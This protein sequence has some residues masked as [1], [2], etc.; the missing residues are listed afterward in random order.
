MG[1][2]RN[3]TTSGIRDRRRPREPRLPFRQ[4]SERRGSPSVFDDQGSFDASEVSKNLRRLNENL[5]ELPALYRARDVALD[6]LLLDSNRRISG[7]P[8]T[9]AIGFVGPEQIVKARALL[10]ERAPDRALAILLHHHVIPPRLSLTAPLLFCLDYEHVVDFARECGA[11]VIVHGH[12]HQPFILSGGELAVLSCGSARFKA[13]GRFAD[14]V[15][16]PSFYALRFE[17]NRM[18]AATLLKASECAPR[19]AA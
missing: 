6:V 12:T 3:A 18:A 10:A 16:E 8:V 14:D 7:W 11:C 13:A 15:A 17:G 2:P 1:A 4:L 9:N 19:T 5:G